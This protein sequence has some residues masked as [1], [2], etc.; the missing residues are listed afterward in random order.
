MPL[1][2][3]RLAPMPMASS[4]PTTNADE[5]RVAEAKR[6][7][8]LSTLGLDALW[9]GLFRLFTMAGDEDTVH[10]PAVTSWRNPVESG[11]GTGVVL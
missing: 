2:C 1:A 11:A 4:A 8:P 6:Q 10:T 9:L 3:I 7:A 5:P